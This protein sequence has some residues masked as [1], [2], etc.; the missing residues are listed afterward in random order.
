MI[1]GPFPM[2]M[3][4]TSEMRSIG[5]TADVSNRVGFTAPEAET[6]LGRLGGV[7]VTGPYPTVTSARRRPRSPPG[8]DQ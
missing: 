2:R 4:E 1:W 5:G 8:S 7:A 6:P 3:P